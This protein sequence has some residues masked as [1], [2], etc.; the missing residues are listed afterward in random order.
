MRFE[1]HW[2]F[3]EISVEFSAS[4]ENSGIAVEFHRN[5]TDFFSRDMILV[6]I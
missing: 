6:S 3:S 5:S 1:A 2:N 4:L